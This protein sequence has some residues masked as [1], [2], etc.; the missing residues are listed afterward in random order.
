MIDSRQPGDLKPE[1]SWLKAEKMLDRHFKRKRA[2]KWSLLLLGIGAVIVSTTIVMNHY[3]SSVSSVYKNTGDRHLVTESNVP[4]ENGSTSV[5]TNMADK[6]TNVE[7]SELKNNTIDKNENQTGGFKAADNAPIKKN[8]IEK[9]IVRENKVP[10]MKNQEKDLNHYKP[11]SKENSRTGLFVNPAK[12]N[13]HS[14]NADETVP[15]KTAAE[16]SPATLAEHPAFANIEKGR[17][18]TQQNTLNVMAMNL[19]HV[20]HVS[21]SVTDQNVVENY[22]GGNKNITLPVNKSNLS[23]MVYGSAGYV[24]KTISSNHFPD[25]ITRRKNEEEGIIAAS[26]GASMMYSV[27]NFSVSI[28][29]EYSGWGEKNI[30]VPYLNKKNLVEHGNNQLYYRTVTD[31]LYIIGNQY[32]NLHQVTDTVFVSHIDTVNQRTYDKQVLSVNGVSKFYYIEIPVEFS[33][34]FSRSKVGIGITVG[35]SP[36]LLVTEKGYYLSKDLTGVEALSEIKSTN[37]FI[38][39]GRFSLD[40]FY[41][42]NEHFN[43]VARPQFKANLGSIFKNEYD[44]NQKYYAT[45]LVLGV[46]YS[47]K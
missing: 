31:T 26:V 8:K 15:E 3:S 32:F 25:Y 9:K 47:I 18:E 44:V 45:G 40:L 42:M 34:R 27:K 36:A 20:D 14:Q 21:F 30:Y 43:L 16:T 28:G 24:S 29:M 17:L 46:L 7:R 1:Q 41:R 33:Y 10:V 19:I 13:I 12:L 39:N 11:G 22:P 38:V 37:R 23:L 5:N 6:K 2:V 4:R 35:I